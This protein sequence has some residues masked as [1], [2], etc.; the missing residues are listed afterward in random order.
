MLKKVSILFFLSFIGSALQAQ[1]AVGDWREHLPYNEV[2]DVTL[3][4]GKAWCATPF[5][6]FVYDT[7]D[8]SV[9]RISKV[10]DLSDTGIS[11]IEYS[12]ENELLLVGYENGNMDLIYENSAYN[13]GDIARSDLVANKSINAVLFIDQFAYLA[14]GFGVV[15]IDLD[16]REVKDTFIIGPDG[17]IIACFDIT[18]DNNTL[19]VATGNG[20]YS[21]DSQSAFLANFSTWTKDTTIPDSNEPLATVDVANGLTMITKEAGNQDEVLYKFEGEGS[22][23]IIDE[24][25]DSV[26]LNDIYFGSEYIILADY[27]RVQ[28]F[29]YEMNSLQTF[30]NLN[31][32]SLRPQSVVADDTDR[33]WIGDERYGLMITDNGSSAQEI[34]PQ[35]PAYFDT[36][37]IDA[38]NHNMWVAS[39]GVNQSWVNNYSKRGFYGMANESWYYAES[40]EG[41][42][43]IVQVNDIME[44]SIDPIDNSHVMFG[45]W[46]EGLIELRNGEVENIYS[47]NNSSIQASTIHSDERYMIAGVDFDSN[48]NCWFTNAYSDEQ[49]HVR[50][51]NGEFKS[52]SFTPDIPDDELVGGVLATRQGQI[53]F[54][55][56]AMESI[57]VFDYN[58]TIDNTSDDRYRILSQEEGEGGLPNVTYCLEEDLEGEIWVGTLE[59]IGVFYTP[60]SI[61]DEETLDVQQILI[62]QGGNIQILLETEAV[63][64]IAL[65]G[66][67]RKWVGT[68][69]SGVFLFSP[70]GQEQV[71]HFTEDNSPL[72][73]NTITDIAINQD[74]G[75]VF[76]S[77]EKGLISFKGT[78]TNFD[79]DINELTIYPNPVR[80]DFEGEVVIDGLGYQTDIKITDI[81]GNVVFSSQSNGGRATWNGKNQN[82]ERVS[83]GI[84][85]VFAS[86]L[87]GSATNVGKIAFVR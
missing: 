54:L 80:P 42:N 13:L 70:D 21:A 65:D 35:G 31:G 77:T 2:I 72:L 48:G 79:E 7:D 6:L 83:T 4:D 30:Y 82:G 24:S 8:Q 37:R 68:A 1:F 18:L 73:S 19:Y 25:W 76:F 10:N 56:P 14:C 3:G 26:L 9:Q 49:L 38:Y 55:L 60:L 59:G 74:N 23:Q 22:W 58:G 28:K 52:F 32:K 44:V 50:K 12:D 87:D 64:S 86:K 15:Q 81:S 78:A 36:R 61:F 16:R 47:G 45:S 85:L 34:A 84:Y 53:W 27:S 71:Y 43:D 51:P 17:T 41:L 40:P 57:V 33:I 29:D 69:N 20:L 66:G 75:E 67:N 5:S 46:E 11:C 62:E 63:T 39:G